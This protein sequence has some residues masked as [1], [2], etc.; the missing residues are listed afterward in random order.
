LAGKI[1]GLRKKV[2]HTIASMA[3]RKKNLGGEKKVQKGKED[4]KGQK[5]WERGEWVVVAPHTTTF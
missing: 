5:F 4:R 2:D 3:R 1:K